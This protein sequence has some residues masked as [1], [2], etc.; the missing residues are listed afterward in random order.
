MSQGV[1]FNTY[2][3]LMKS[4]LLLAI[5]A[6]TAA[7][8][9]ASASA[10]SSSS[11]P[12]SMA[13]QL[14][15]AVAGAGSGNIRV[16][17]SLLDAGDAEGA[18]AA[19]QGEPFNVNNTSLGPRTILQKLVALNDATGVND[20]LDNGADINAGPHQVREGRRHYA[21]KSI[22]HTA[23][24][25]APYNMVQ[26]VITAGA[27][28]NAFDGN[29]HS[30]LYIAAIEKRSPKLVRLLL[31]HG[32]NPSSSDKPLYHACRLSLCKIATILAKAGA[33]ADD[34][35]ANAD[36][37]ILHLAA[38]NCDRETLMQILQ[39][40]P[41]FTRLDASAS[42]FLDA[43]RREHT[44]RGLIASNAL[45]AHLRNP[46]YRQRL[47]GIDNDALV[48]VY[49]EG[50]QRPPM[51]R[52]MEVGRYDNMERVFNFLII[53]AYPLT[54][55]PVVNALL[56]YFLFQCAF[57]IGEDYEFDPKSVIFMILTIF[58]VLPNFL[59]NLD[60]FGDE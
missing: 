18:K 5:F 29:E 27:D 3:T 2:S 16:V 1:I 4:S 38:V 26:R 46:T 56:G 50:E 9:L 59:R 23:L 36:T 60:M 30:A 25:F 48:R 12:S 32:A 21:H 57:E 58:S 52:L 51:D 15:R 11:R 22:L 34:V 45:A 39:N 54:T 43:A 53:Q 28:V 35:P 19:F 55:H 17:H 49:A 41:D 8:I 42:S 14:W 47:P 44:V 40:N 6:A 20:F 13:Q 24:E 31:R 33:N 37:T 10:S 7:S